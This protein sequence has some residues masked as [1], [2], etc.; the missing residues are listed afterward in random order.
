MSVHPESATHYTSNVSGQILMYYRNHGK[1][2]Q[3]LD[4]CGSWCFSACDEKDLE[5][6]LHAL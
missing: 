5:K 3:Y 6:D 4:Y 2:W 1:S